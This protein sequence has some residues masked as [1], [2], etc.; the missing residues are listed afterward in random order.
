MIKILVNHQASFTHLCQLPARVSR[1]PFL[2]EESLSSPLSDFERLGRHFTWSE[3]QSPS[4]IGVD[5]LIDVS[6][7]NPW[8]GT[9]MMLA[10][11]A[12]VH[13]RP[14]AP[15]DEI[16]CRSLKFTSDTANA[17]IGRASKRES[18]NL[19]PTP[20]NGLFD[21]RVMSRNHARLVV[22]VDKKLAYLRDGGS[23]HGT[24]VNGKKLPSEEDHLLNQ[25]DIITFGTEVVRGKDTFPPLKVRF[26]L[27][28]LQSAQKPTPSNTFCVPDDDDN[29]ADTDNAPVVCPAAS[30]SDDDD[31]VFRSDSDDQS[32]VEVSSP[33][34]SPLK[35]GSP[36]VALHSSANMLTDSDGAA[37]RGSEES[38][39]N[40]DCDNFEQPLVTPRMTPPPAVDILDEKPAEELTHMDVFV[41][42]TGIE[43]SLDSSPEEN[44]EWDEDDDS[45]EYGDE[46]EIHSQCSLDS[47]MEEDP[48]IFDSYKSMKASQVLGIRDLIAS[49]PS[50]DFGETADQLISATEPRCNDGRV[51]KSSL[52]EPK[53]GL[54]GSSF[55]EHYPSQS[56]PHNVEASEVLPVQAPQPTNM[57]PLSLLCQPGHSRLLQN[58]LVGL[59]QNYLTSPL[60]WHAGSA[61]T[62]PIPVP[63]RTSY[64]DGPFVNESTAAGGNV[65]TCNIAEP[66][67]ARTPTT[68]PTGKDV[69]VKVQD[70]QAT[71]VISE[72]AITLQSSL[73]PDAHSPQD[74][75]SN[76]LEARPLK[77]KAEHIEESLTDLSHPQGSQ[78]LDCAQS[79][80]NLPEAQPQKLSV[81]QDMIVDPHTPAERTCNVESSNPLTGVEYTNTSQLPDVGTSSERPSKRAKKSSARTFASHAATAALGV[82]IGALGTI[83][84]LASLP[85]DY[86]HE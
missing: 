70:A 65:L 19:V 22:R 79:K 52:S 47:D 36:K 57:L 1:Y 76:V 29:D 37:Y 46:E 51:T 27:D 16:P 63:P 39:I 15:I 10:T 5:F 34:T 80:T 62:L 81:D 11:E 78:T 66:A 6:E 26:E 86:F 59:Q 3:P 42:E 21:S 56:V 18:K 41:E 73:S 61:Y 32:V 12:I 4:F 55:I 35:K 50:F 13:L 49:D 84:T 77:R 40:L 24:F 82:A 74:P 25:G 8:T 23:M 72:Q 48:Y 7:H 83:V 9:D 30:S 60:E 67:V 38:P 45:I 58:S 69:E 53:A 85:P 28:W 31:S 44:S 2:L 20:E 68:I 14:L 33:F 75:C 54:S 71:T 43:S 64:S 17:C